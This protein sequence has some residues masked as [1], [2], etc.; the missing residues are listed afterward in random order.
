MALPRV[1]TSMGGGAW[2]SGGERGDCRAFAS[3]RR[4]GQGRTA[5][6][7]RVA[8]TSGSIVG[9]GSVGCRGRRLRPFALVEDRARTR[10][11]S[12]V[13]EAADLP[14]EAVGEQGRAGMRA[15]GVDLHARIGQVGEA[16]QFVR[17]VPDDVEILEHALDQR[18]GRLAALAALE[19]RQVGARDAEMRGHVLQQEPRSR[20][21]CR[22]RSPKGVIA[23]I[24]RRAAAQ[25]DIERPRAAVLGRGLLEADDEG[26]QIRQA[27]PMRHHAAAAR[28]APRRAP[29]GAPAPPLPVIDQDEAVPC[30]CARRRK[31]EQRRMG[32]LLAHAVQVDG[33][34]RPRLARRGAGPAASLRSRGARAAARLRAR[35]RRLAGRGREAGVRQGRR[36]GARPRPEASGSGGGSVRAEGRDAAG[37]LRPR[38]AAPRRVSEAAAPRLR[39]RRR[40]S[41]CGRRTKKRVG[42]RIRPGPRAGLRPAADEEIAPRRP[43]DG[44]AG[45]LRDHQPAQGLGAVEGERQ[46][47]VEPERQ[48]VGPEGAVDREAAARRRGE[49]RPRRSA[50]RP[51]RARRPRGRRC[52][53]GSGA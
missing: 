34:R 12:S 51:D 24:L 17:L 45:I 16:G 31:R 15:A 41:G 49:C 26:A 30:A 5:Q 20:R 32:L 7:G 46:R 9:R 40:P 13:V 10:S 48:A 28:R 35:V 50:R 27:Q 22:T 36:G 19:G 1:S 11:I 3:A 8:V 29:T 23:P 18:P 25:P 37:H 33:V 39:H 38:G 52:R 4:G 53:S 42:W 6:V 47:A 21:S 2:G 14:G 43:D 44:R